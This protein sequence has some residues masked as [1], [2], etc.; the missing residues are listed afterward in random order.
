[1]YDFAE[2]LPIPGMTVLAPRDIHELKAMIRWTGDWQQPVAIRYG[3]SSVDQSMMYPY[4]G[5]FRL[6][7]WEQLEDGR[8]CVILAVGSMV[9]EAIEAHDALLHDHI[10][11]AVINCSTVKPLDEKTLRAIGDRPVITMEEHALTGGFG[12]AICTW[13][14]AE[15]RRGPLM[16]FG[17]HDTF[18]QHGRREQLLR[19][20][21]L[22][23]KQMAVR[24]KTLLKENETDE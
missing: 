24:I 9:R 19:Y 16:C 5:K 3:R 23:G 11:A 4:R 8:D 20:L 15:E 18:V 12:A 13:C 1:V 22:T 17:I 2:L 6:G 7:E 21:G 10:E 14:T